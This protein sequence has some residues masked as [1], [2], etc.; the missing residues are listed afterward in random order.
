M[1]SANMGPG[2]EVCPACR[3]IAFKK[4]WP[5]VEL[6]VSQMLEGRRNECL[7]C[8]MLLDA[9]HLRCPTYLEEYG[10]ENHRVKLV[11]HNYTSLTVIPPSEAGGLFNVLRELGIVLP[12]FGNFYTIAYLSR[13]LFFAL[14]LLLTV[15][16]LSFHR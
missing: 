2:T 16:I 4:G 5:G 1:L 11:L 6:S 13:C 8:S 9:L 14:E 10:A 15:N 3:N 12:L 7:G